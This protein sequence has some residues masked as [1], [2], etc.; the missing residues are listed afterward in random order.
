[1]TLVEAMDEIRM[2]PLSV[3]LGLIQQL[4]EDARCGF[5]ATDKLD[6]E[7]GYMVSRLQYLRNELLKR[8][9]RASPHE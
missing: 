4:L 8:K 1:M 9:D 7:L 5:D 3:R 6:E 2:R